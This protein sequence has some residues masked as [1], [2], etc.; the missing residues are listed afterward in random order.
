MHKFFQ[1]KEENL[2]VESKQFIQ[3]VVHDKYGKP[4]EK[5]GYLTY[6]NASSLLKTETLA[7]V[8]WR[9]GLKRTGLIGRKIGHFPLWLKNGKRIDTTVIQIVDNHVVKY[10]PPEEFNPTMRLHL[11]NYKGWACMLIGSE[12]IDPNKVTSPYAGLF[13][14]SGVMPKKNL[15]RFIISPQAAILPGTELNVTHFRVGDVVDVRGKT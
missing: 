12:S 1:K 5:K 7:P 3:D 8:E 10:Y 6:E 11:K 4:V 2:T 14:G 9:W 15:S 13:K